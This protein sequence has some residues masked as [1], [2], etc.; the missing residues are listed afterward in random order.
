MYRSSPSR[1]V[2]GRWLRQ[3]RKA[4]RSRRSRRNATSPSSRTSRQSSGRTFETEQRAQ[5]ELRRS[6]RFVNTL[7]RSD[8]SISERWSYGTDVYETRYDTTQYKHGD[9]PKPSTSQ[10]KRSRTSSHDRKKRKSHNTTNSSSTD[11]CVAYCTRSRT[12]LRS[13]ESVCEQTPTSV[14]ATSL[15]RVS[16][17]QGA[18]ETP[19]QLP[20]SQTEG[21]L[22]P[23]DER[24][25]A[26]SPFSSS[27][28]TD[29][30][31][32]DYSVYSPTTSR[33]K[34][35]KRKR[36]THRSLSHKKSNCFIDIEDCRKKFK[37]DS[38]KSVTETK[39]YAIENLTPDNDSDRA[40]ASSAQACT[41]R[42]RNRNNR[43]LGP[44][45][46]TVISD[47]AGNV[48][49]SRI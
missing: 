41:Y 40:E 36:S 13:S 26:Y 1:V 6:S 37:I 4:S 32:S 33:R 2:G 15:P 31:D 9:T 45:T 10:V 24:D 29:L 27:T 30:L 25:F 22:L 23:L 8:Y 11:D 16:S 39:P 34:G 19:A 12:A 46:S 18:T 49:N 28:I 35:K 20:D 7:P 44:P 5:V 38:H 42:L 17:N 48:S 3:V 47:S 21:G 14:K 43:D